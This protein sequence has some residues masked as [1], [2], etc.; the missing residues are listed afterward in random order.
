MYKEC[1]TYGSTGDAW[2]EPFLNADI[3]WMR[4]LSSL[5][6]LADV[7]W[8][9]IR[10]HVRRGGSIMDAGCGMGGVAGVSLSEGLQGDGA[11]FL[12]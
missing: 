12:Q 8:R 7:R 1:R 11:R 2:A 4:R 6:M 3:N 5:A 9:S 10:R